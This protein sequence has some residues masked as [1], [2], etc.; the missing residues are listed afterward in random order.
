MYFHDKQQESISFGIVAHYLKPY[1]DPYVQRLI[2]LYNGNVGVD[3]VVVGNIQIAADRV[4]EIVE[5]LVVGDI[6][7][8]V[9]GEVLA[10]VGG[11]GSFATATE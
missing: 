3:G 6:V 4:L 5:L 1:L 2:L 11:A 8:A 9:G 10:N 7:D